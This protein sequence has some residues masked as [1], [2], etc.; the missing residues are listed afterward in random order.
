M[1]LLFALYFSS[2]KFK[3]VKIY[4]NWYNPFCDETLYISW[5][6]SGVKVLEVHFLKKIS[7]TG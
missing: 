4:Q 2:L 3:Y 1:F 7:R 5:S 6:N